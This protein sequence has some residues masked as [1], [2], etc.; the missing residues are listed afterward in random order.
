M[1]D[2][3]VV[4]SD[5]IEPANWARYQLEENVEKLDIWQAGLL[6]TDPTIAAS[7]MGQSTGRVLD[8]PIYDDLE[9]AASEPVNDDPEDEIEADNVTT[10][11]AITVREFRAKAFANMDINQVITMD[12]P[13]A[14]IQSRIGNWWQRAHKRTLLAILK[15]IFADNVANDSS[16]LTVDTNTTIVDEDIINAAFKQGDRFSDFVGMWMHSTPYKKL[17][18]DDLIDFRPS[19]EGKMMIP[20]YLGLRVVVDD[21]VPVNTTEYTTYLFKQGAVHYQEMPVMVRG[22]PVVLWENPSA[23]HGSGMTKL[24]TRR[25]FVMHPKGWTFATTS[26]ANPFPA[27]SELDDAATW[28]RIVDSVKNVGVVQLL[29]TES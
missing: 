15:G 22:G 4:L 28:N 12:D 16:D 3:P 29:T 9:S 10:K 14:M 1:A 26:F 17:V 20:Y 25:N 27:D 23:G 19:S 13:L 24:I 2:T 6:G 5:L 7:V 18:K 8:I 21:G 11:T